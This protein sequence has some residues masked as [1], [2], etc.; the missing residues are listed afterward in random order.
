MNLPDT[1]QYAFGDIVF[2][3]TGSRPGV[4]TGIMFRENGL[5]YEV[6]WARLEIENHYACEISKKKPEKNKTYTEADED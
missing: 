4:V 3:K 1:T 2:H 5:I 6:T